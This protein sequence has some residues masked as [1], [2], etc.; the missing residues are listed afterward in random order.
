MA[1]V[2]Q[3]NGWSHA[4]PALVSQAA[5]TGAGLAHS[6]RGIEL[7][8]QGWFHAEGNRKEQDQLANIH[9]HHIRVAVDERYKA[10]LCPDGRWIN[11]PAVFPDLR[12][13]GTATSGGISPFP[14]R[15][16]QFFLPTSSADLGGVSGTGGSTCGENR[17]ETA[18]PSLVMDENG[19]STWV[20]LPDFSER[21]AAAVLFDD[22]AATTHFGRIQQGSLDNG[23]LAEA[24]Q[25][26]SLRPRL[27]RQLFH[28]WDVQRSVYIAK[29]FK[30]G[31]W[32]RVEVDDYVPVGAPSKD[33]RDG[34]VPLCCRSEF[35][36]HVLWPCLVEKAY[37]KAHTLRKSCGAVADF[38]GW[39][40][41]SG[42]GR[43]EEALADLTGGVA[44]RF[45]TS[46]V[47]ADRLF[48]YI[49]A[50]QRDTLF[51]CRPHEL[52]CQ[53]HGIRLNP[54]YPN[55]INRACVY[56]GRPYIQVVSA[57]PGVFDGG[58]QDISV[59]FGL[60][61]CDQYPETSA[62]GFFW[63]SASDFHEYFDVIFE[64]RLVNSGDVSIAGMPPPRIPRSLEVPWAEIV[65]ANPGIISASSAPEFSI[66][67]PV[68]TCPCEV[69]ASLEQVDRRMLRK[70]DNTPVQLAVLLKVYE[71]VGGVGS[72]TVYHE[73]PV[74]KSNWFPM[75]DAVVAFTAVGG[76]E[77]RVVATLP[78]AVSI[79]RM[80]FRCY[81]SKP[82]VRVSAADSDSHALVASK[83]PSKAQRL[84]MVGAGVDAV[85]DDQPGL[86]DKDHDS[87]RKPE[88]DID[89]GWQEL[90]D[91]FKQDCCLM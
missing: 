79:E 36:P 12:L 76:G 50:L 59:P 55:A 70:V 82:D 87:L 30:H 2:S 31:T 23:Y 37:A 44:G 61:H 24:L 7:K 80:I 22:N 65:F 81:S 84:T 18:V 26:I 46:D 8:S 91:E 86:L 6:H 63:V 5:V 54:Y 68:H 71:A 38:G 32:L 67:V 78:D 89:P 72:N 66:S 58:L 35:F 34:H 48:C 53:L 47:S 41:L 51:V 62:E 49:H 69:V 25:A 29:F 17:R 16:A 10:G 21:P 20:R 3:D 88:F 64:C 52:N 11:D 77:F 33:G 42:G 74:C 1:A 83:G 13:L 60:R 9:L 56:E 15:D 28:C 4:P 85:A 43:V 90:K 73:K 75:R 27:A 14:P 45:R 40:A 39:E 19:G 57:A